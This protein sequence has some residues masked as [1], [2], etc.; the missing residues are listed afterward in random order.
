MFFYVLILSH[1][2]DH[3][4][5][6][7]SNISL[8]YYMVRIFD[9]LIVNTKFYA[10]IMKITTFDSIFQSMHM[11]HKFHKLEIVLAPNYHLY[12]FPIYELSLWKYKNKDLNGT[13]PT[14]PISAIS[15]RSR[16]IIRFWPFKGK[17][18]VSSLPPR[19]PS[20]TKILSFS[21]LSSP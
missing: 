1:L 15:F 21:L 2:I 13:Y 11:M 12:L 19:P 20:A 6:S 10:G 4:L 18:F 5:Y 14:R 8:A 7:F 17:K 9:K 16:W 3:F